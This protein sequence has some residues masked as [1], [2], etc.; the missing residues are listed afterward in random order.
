MKLLLSIL[1]ISWTIVTYVKTNIYTKD[2]QKCEK[3]KHGNEH[4]YKDEYEEDEDEPVFYEKDPKAREPLFIWDPVRVGYER[5]IEV[6]A[7]KK[8][9]MVTAAV[10]PKVFLIEDF[11]SE[12]EADH[13]VEKAQYYGLANSGLHLDTKITTDKKYTSGKARDSL[14]W[15]GRWDHNDDGKITLSEVIKT[16]EY[17]IKLYLNES[18][19]MDVF[20]GLGMKEL[21]DGIINEEEWTTFNTAGLGE[22]WTDIRENNPRFRD[23]FSE[24]IWLKHTDSSDKIMHNLREKVIKLTNLPR[25][26]V[27]GGEPLQ[28]LRY[29]PFGHYHAHFD[30]QDPKE[31]PNTK[32]C[33]LDLESQPY[34][35][36]LC[37]LMTIIYY[38]NDVEGGGETAF[39]VADKKGY[40]EK[41]F[42]ERRGGDLY[43]LSQFCHNA[44]LVVKPKKGRAVM[45][46][47]H[48]LDDKGWLGDMD[49]YS[50]HGGCDITKGIK[51][52]ANNW[53]TSPPA[54][55]SHQDSLY[56]HIDPEGA[57]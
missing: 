31:Y 50:L 36:R 8:V 48:F 13:I 39:P 34:N 51:W 43:N 47:N 14:G 28:V 22:A 29:Q 53:I 38:L 27:E 7:G 35:C 33:H 2:G 42:R 4:C 18:E 44:S 37:R 9:K 54:E 21:D 24:Q 23:R 3:D 32:C 56:L 49:L 57:F 15:R 10:Q 41:D 12:Q 20:R 17:N 16:C 11:L 1:L 52:M 30:G 26:I 19:M 6:E 46:Y 55:F 45:F 25:Y 5:E 40:V